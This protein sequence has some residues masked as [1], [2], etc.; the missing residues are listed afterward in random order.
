M[1]AAIVTFVVAT[2]IVIG[3][4][5][6]DVIAVAIVTDVGVEGVEEEPFHVRWSKMNTK[7]K[8]N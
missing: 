6:V 2:V 3:V 1:G 7:I 8:P 5:V 4:D